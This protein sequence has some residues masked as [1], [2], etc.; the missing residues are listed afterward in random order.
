MMFFHL[1]L[2]TASMPAATIRRLISIRARP[3]LYA[4]TK[5]GPSIGTKP[6]VDNGSGLEPHLNPG[7]VQ[8]QAELPILTKPHSFVETPSA[9]ECILVHG[10]TSGDNV[11]EDPHPYG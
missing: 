8:P 7:L 3:Q 1:T 5:V 11:G 9:I 10:E 6:V 4:L 2:P